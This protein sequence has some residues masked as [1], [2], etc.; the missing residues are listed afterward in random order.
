MSGTSQT[1]HLLCRD[2]LI[3]SVSLV[4][5]YVKY[6]LNIYRNA[7]TNLIFRNF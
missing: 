4:V 7:A 3:S 1:Q 2:V 5:Y 6:F